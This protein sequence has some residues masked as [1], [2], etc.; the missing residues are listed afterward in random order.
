MGQIELHT[1]FFPL[2]WVLY[3]CT[4]KAS[5]NGSPPFAVPWRRPMP[6]PLPPG[7]HQVQVW[8]PYLFFSKM[9]LA[10]VVVNVGEGTAQRI[11]WAPTWYFVLLP[12][13]IRVM[14]PTL[15]LV[16]PAGIAPLQQP[17]PLQQAPL[18]AVPAGAWHPDPSGRYRQRWWDGSAWTDHVTDG[19]TTFADPTPMPR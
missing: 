6:I 12:G 2:A 9:G 8:V 13:K 15:G 3:L 16:A 18:A 4:P 1:S 5:I 10:T 17:M 14:A 11:E 7:Q 19:I